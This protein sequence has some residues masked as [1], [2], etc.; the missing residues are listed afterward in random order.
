MI[1]GGYVIG[2]VKSFKYL[3]YFVQ[4]D[5]GFGMNVKH[6]IKYGWKKW[7]EASGVLCDMEIPMKLKGKFYW[8]V[9]RPTMLYGLK[10]CTVDW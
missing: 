1:I 10:C 3:G 5:G 8:R 4:R 9:V 6:R 7:R 2:E